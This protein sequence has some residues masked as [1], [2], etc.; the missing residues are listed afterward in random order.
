MLQYKAVLPLTLELLKN[1]QS[2]PYFNGLRLAGGT[3]LA[4]QIGHRHSVDLDFFGQAIF[5]MT[6]LLDELSKLGKVE[7]IKSSKVIKIFFINDIKVDF[8]TYTYPWLDSPLIKNGITIA[9]A[10]DIAA[11]KIAA[12]TNRGTKKDFW[13]LYFLLQ[14]FT[15]EEILSF[16][17][18]KY[19]D[20]S[21]FLAIKSL[22]YFEDA[23]LEEDPIGIFP[24]KWD[25]IKA[26]IEFEHKKYLKNLQIS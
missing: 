8:V 5:D 9:S 20:G 23:E 14:Q 15:L 12:I 19:T 22:I 3:G 6:E 2:N 13:D 1:I 25:I 24:A 11:M 4:L 21:E 7:T 18:R 16:Y 10:M 17:K 26:H